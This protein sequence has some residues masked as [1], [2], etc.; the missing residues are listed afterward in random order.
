MAEMLEELPAS[1]DES[2]DGD[3]IEGR[4]RKDERLLSKLRGNAW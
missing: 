4:Q 3:V 2:D 1:L